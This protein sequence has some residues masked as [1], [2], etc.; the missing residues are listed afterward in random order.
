MGCLFCG[1]SP[2]KADS[3]YICGRCVQILLNADQAELAEGRA[4]CIEK[5]YSR[6]TRTIDSF[7][8]P[9]GINEQ[10]KPAKKRRRHINRKRI[11]RAIGDKKKRIGRSTIP[12]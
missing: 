9:E 6:K 1:Q 5:G 2:Y 10:R 8:I 7:L 4:R 11:V 12:A 3:E